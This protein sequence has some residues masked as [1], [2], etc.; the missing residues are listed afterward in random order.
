MRYP[1]DLLVNMYASV[2]IYR[3]DGTVVITHGGVEMGQGINTKVGQYKL[4]QWSA[5]QSKAPLFT[6]NSKAWHVEF[7]VEGVK[8]PVII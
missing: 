6:R 2:S 8:F 7:V 4:R 3:N 1:V 5:A